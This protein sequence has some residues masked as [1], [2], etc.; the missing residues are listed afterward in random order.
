M[1]SQRRSRDTAS[2]FMV[3]DEKNKETKTDKSRI[4][5]IAAHFMFAVLLCVFAFAGISRSTSALHV[6]MAD[7]ISNMP[8]HALAADEDRGQDAEPQDDDDEEEPSVSAAKG[9]TDGEYTGSG[10]GYGGRITMKLT[11]EGGTIK[12]LEI[13]SASGETP[14]YLNMAK[15]V[16]PKIISA[17]SAN[18]DG[19]SG[20]TYSSNGIKTAAAEALKQ[21]GGDGTVNLKKA[22]PKQKGKP[23]SKSKK[24]QYKKPEGGWKDGTFTGSARGFG[25]TVSVRVTI[26]NGKIK[27]ISASGKGETSSYWRR[28]QAVR[29]R[30]IKKQNPRV[31]AVS[32]A[33]YSSNGIINAVIAALNKAAKSKKS[34]P[35]DQEITTAENDYVLHEAETAS[36]RAKAKT[37]LSYRSS[38]TKVVTVDKNG[39]LT[40]VSAGKAQ[41]TITAA[42]NKKYRKAVKKVSVTVFAKS[43][44]DPD[45][46]DDPDKPDDPDNPDDPD[47]PDDNKINGTFSGSAKGYGG[48]VTASVVIENSVITTINVEGKKESPK[49]WFEAKKIVK[50]MINNQTWDVDAVSGATYSSD[51]IRYAVKQ[52]LE[53]A[54][55]I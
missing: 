21:A 20:A 18:V 12:S 40:G 24:K 8:E 37:K 31:D 55:L 41:I 6:R 34:G 33:T 5:M 13:V 48:D 39:R 28:A 45:Q 1:A 50:K 44:E 52:A 53:S 51:G 9:L 19:V 38:D 3:M 49:Y 23:G 22:A 27:K 32:G 42:K 7:V 36:I 16:I 43:E 15:A 29:G 26:K 54:G 11:V 35:K 14:A 2:L 46:P 47:Q 17:G 10:Q 30:I 25:G 4:L